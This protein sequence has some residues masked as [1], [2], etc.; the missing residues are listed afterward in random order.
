MKVSVLVPIY[1]VEPFVRKCAESLFSQSFDDVEFIFVDDASPD[2]SIQ[3][4]REVAALYLDRDVKIVSHLVNMGSHA[5]RNTALQNAS[6]EYVFYCDSDDYV[7]KDMLKVMY[8]AALEHDADIVYCDFFLTFENNERYM[9]NPDFTTGDQLLREGFLAGTAKYNLW[10]KLIRRSLFVDN[11]IDFASHSMGED[12]AVIML[13]S[14]ARNVHHVRQ[15]FYH[16]V[17]LN[18]DAYSNNF[19]QRQLEDIRYNVDRITSFLEARYQKESLKKELSFFKLNAKLPFL[20]S[21]DPKMYGIWKE[22]YPEANPYILA[23]KALPLRTRLLQCCAAHNLFFLVKLYYLAV[24]K[25]VYGVI[26]K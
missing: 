9:A 24:Y 14:Y 13:A 1:K 20:I 5:T 7:E 18:A 10:N 4:V 17:K 16:Y 23:N 25:F 11:K 8:E 21:S 15:G 3:I 12:M 22:W 2:R 26:Y 19:S 6:G